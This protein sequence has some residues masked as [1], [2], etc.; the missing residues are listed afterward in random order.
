MGEKR[1]ENKKALVRNFPDLL[2]NTTLKNSKNGLLV[3][4]IPC[5]D[6]FSPLVDVSHLSW[7]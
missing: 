6:I 1:W 7:G 4:N 5:F 3:N 2:A